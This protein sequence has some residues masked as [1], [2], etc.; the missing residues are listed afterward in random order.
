ME[1]VPVLEEAA[2]NALNVRAD[3]TYLDATFGRGGHA[4]LVLDRLGARGL[5][6]ALDADPDAIAFGERE[7]GG[8][9]VAMAQ[10]VEPFPPGDVVILA[11]DAVPEHLPRIGAHEARQDT[12]QRRFAGAVAAGDD[13]RMAGLQLR[14]QADEDRPVAAEAC[15]LLQRQPVWGLIQRVRGHA[16][17]M[18]R[19]R[20]TASGLAFG[21]PQCIDQRALCE[22]AGIR[23]RWQRRQ[24]DR[25]RSQSRRQ[26]A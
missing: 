1:H 25:W 20:S 24:E 19:P 6:I 21:A 18:K 5:L 12:Q 23:S 9:A 11:I 4:R 13:Q 17:L 10:I 7:F 16:I 26:E 22:K 3:G 2:V 15:Q 14:I 8:D